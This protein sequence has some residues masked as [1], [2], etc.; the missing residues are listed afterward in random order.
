L[1][2]D[3]ELTSSEL[4]AR[5]DLHKELLALRADDVSSSE[6]EAPRSTWHFPDGAPIRLICGQV[7]AAKAGAYADPASPNFTQLHGLADSDALIELFGHIRMINP[8]SD[9][10]FMLATD[11]KPDDLTA[12][13]VLIG[14]IVNNPAVM[15][16]SRV[17]DLPVRQVEDDSIEDGEVFEVQRDGRS[18]RFLPTFLE[19]DPALGLIEDVALFARIPN[20]HFL[21]RTLTLCNGVFSRGVLGSVRTLTDTQL[22]ESNEAYLASR[23]SGRSDFGML[24]RVPVFRGMASTPDFSNEYHRLYVWPPREEPG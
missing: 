12:H 20:P 19:D 6:A 4:A 22:R 1:L 3:E 14:G 5:D 13:V 16:F 17:T 10:R 23:F 2:P 9:V 11:M 24:L 15:Y 18:R 7:L 8:A 21:D